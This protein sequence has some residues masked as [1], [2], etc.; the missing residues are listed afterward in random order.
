MAEARTSET[1]QAFSPIYVTPKNIQLFYFLFENVK[2]QPCDR[3]NSF[4]KLSV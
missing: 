1:G 4:H 2:Q 3:S